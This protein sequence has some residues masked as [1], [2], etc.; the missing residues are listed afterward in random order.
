MLLSKKITQLACLALLCNTYQTPP[1]PGTAPNRSQTLEP[2]P[3]SEMTQ[4]SEAKVVQQPFADLL[5]SVVNREKHGI[6]AAEFTVKRDSAVL[7]RYNSEM[8][9]LGGCA[10]LFLPQVQPVKDRFIISGFGNYNGEVFVIAPDGHL[11]AMSGGKF[12]IS[13]DSKYLLTYHDSDVSG[14]SVFNL[15]TMTLLFSEEQENLEYLGNCYFLNNTFLIEV[16]GSE[17]VAETK[18]VSFNFNKEQFSKPRLIAM[19]ALQKG[20]K[21]EV[22]N[23]LSDLQYCNC[24]R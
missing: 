8:D 4:A 15:K 16:S 5:I 11:E 23:D 18:V 9:P 17:T 20:I 22:H 21:L 1:S 24:G 3:T 14:L 7:E 12:F 2:A 19:N 6:C 13:P 10:G